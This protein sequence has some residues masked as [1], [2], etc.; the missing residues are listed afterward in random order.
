VEVKRGRSLT[1]QATYPSHPDLSATASAQGRLIKG[2]P[3]PAR[4]KE[5]KAHT[6]AYVLVLSLPPRSL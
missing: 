2:G 1:R 6:K 5:K 3:S 4:G